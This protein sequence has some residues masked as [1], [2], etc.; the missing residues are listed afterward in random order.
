MF[1]GSKVLPLWK[2]ASWE[3]CG[4]IFALARFQGQ[5]F[6]RVRARF[7]NKVFVAAVVIIEYFMITENNLSSAVDTSLKVVRIDLVQEG[8]FHYEMYGIMPLLGCIFEC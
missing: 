5:R 1:T 7:D 3:I 8:V 6:F 4:D 2:C